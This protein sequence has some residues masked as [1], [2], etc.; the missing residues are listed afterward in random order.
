[1]VDENGETP[2]EYK[3]SRLIKAYLRV[4]QLAYAITA[5]PIGTV[6]SVAPVYLDDRDMPVTH[7]GFFLAGGELLGI[8]A[9][10]VAEHYEDGFI[11]RRPYDLHFIN[12]SLAIVLILIGVWP[13]NVIYL[14]AVC[15]M[16]VQTF[17]SASKPVVSENIHRLSVMTKR[18]SHIVFAEANTWR[19]IGNASIGLTTPLCYAL[20]HSLPF[21]LIGGIMLFYLGVVFAIDYKIKSIYHNSKTS[22]INVDASNNSASSGIIE[23]SDSEDDIFTLSER[24]A[25]ERSGPPSPSIASSKKSSAV[26]TQDSKSTDRRKRF[27]TISMLK[28]YRN[29]QNSTEKKMPMEVAVDANGLN[30]SALGNSGVSVSALGNSGVSVSGLGNTAT[31]STLGKST[32]GSVLEEGDEEDGDNESLFPSVTGVKFGAV[33]DIETNAG[34][35]FGAVSDIETNVVIDEEKKTPKKGL[36]FALPEETEEKK[37]PKKGLTFAIPEENK[38]KKVPKRG[39]RFLVPEED[40]QR[41]F[42]GFDDP[43]D[44]IAYYL[45]VWL[46]P[47][48]DAVITRLPFSYLL[49]ALVHIPDFKIVYAALGLFGYQMGRAISQQIQVW[50]CDTFINYLM[51]VIALCGYIAYVVYVEVAP[52]GMWWFVPILVTGAAET[53]PIQQL[54]LCGLFGDLHEEDMALRNAVKTSHTWTGVGSMVAFI[55]G[56]QIYDEFGVRGMAYLG[57]TVM[58]LKMAINVQIDI[59][60]DRKEKK[61]KRNLRRNQQHYK[62][63]FKSMRF[64]DEF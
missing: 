35:K 30:V 54:Y 48:L 26:S 38:E 62:N 60:H 6:L 10:I 32:L 21:Y 23:G 61:T 47:F 31:S 24:L 57:L 4:N 19:R 33:S 3:S 40:S 55:V 63:L 51:N 9:M 29:R 36:T 58:I 52:D 20:Y 11:F 2:K 8:G 1:M 64:G 45:I 41:R 42:E 22:Q 14:S 39:I 16:L 34:V 25:N 46:F 18:E 7:I 15:M 37:V 56:S 27:S 49:I 13:E 59:L 43:F 53:L 12:A 17:N 5:F 44:L 50:R 28:S